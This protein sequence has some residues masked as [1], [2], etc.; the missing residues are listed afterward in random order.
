MD[1]FEKIIKPSIE[2]TPSRNNF[3]YSKTIEHTPDIQNIK[4][5]TKIL[6]KDSPEF[7]I[8]EYSD[9]KNINLPKLLSTKT[10]L[11]NK[12]N[13]KLTLSKGIKVYN[14]KIYNFDKSILSDNLFKNK[15]MNKALE[16]KD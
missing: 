13:I 4:E 5:T 12:S 6:N 2:N 1:K 16:K 15:I 3:E 11:R 14:D 8:N 7:Q 10:I 9:K